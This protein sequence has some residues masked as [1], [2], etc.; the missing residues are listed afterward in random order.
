[1]SVVIV[2]A[3]IGGLTA[4]LALRAQG[5]EVQV[6]EQARELS[7]IGAGLQIASNAV[8]VLDDLGL[9]ERLAEVSVAAR[10]IRFRDLASDELLFETPLGAQAAKH[11]GRPFYQVH[12]ADLLGVL[13]DALPAE[14]LRLGA[15]VT[16]VERDED[17]ATVVLAGGER[18]T[19]DAVI[20]ADGIHSRV[21]E[22]MLGPQEP[23]FSGML[24]WRALLSLEAAEDLGLDHSCDAWLGPGRSVVTYW[25]RRG[26]LFNVIGFV[27]ARE[28][29]RESWTDSGDVYEMRASFAG[30]NALI[31]RL[32]DKID[33]AFI[34]GVYF[35]DPA[36]R[37]STGRVTLL[38]DAAHATQPYLAQGACQSVEDAAVLA[39]LLRRAGPGGVAAALAEYERRRWPRTTKVQTVARA[40]ERFW[41]ETDPERIRAR[42]GRFRGL[43][44]IDALTDTVWGWLYH[45]DPIAS[46]DRPAEESLGLATAH[47][48][49]RMKR[50]ESQR[51][52]DL[53]RAAFTPEDHAGSWQGLRTGY[54]RFL[55]ANASAPADAKVEEVDAG[56]VRALWVGDGGGPTVLHVHGG[57]FM[58]GSA[59]GAVGLADRIA[60]AVGGRVL[61]VDYR[62]AP[63][64]PYP[65]ALDDVL[66]AY[67]WLVE[68]DD[69]SPPILCGESAGGGLALSAALALRDRRLTP[70]AAIYVM[71]PLADL[72]VG[73]L[74]VD[75]RKGQDPVLDRDLLTE[76]SAAYL[77]GHNPRDPLASPIHGNFTGLPPLLVHASACEALLDDARRVIEVAR[78]AGVDAELRLFQDTVHIFPLLSFLPEADE[79]LDDLAAFVRER[80]AAAAHPRA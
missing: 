26:E 43:A 1:M 80:T 46:L 42:N 24:G 56:G 71:S 10:A 66:A 35:H 52:A 65:A 44:R 9:A 23:H 5:I 68:Q 4:A 48:A 18:I 62:L 47:D 78:A 45:Y 12:R 76:M 8:R 22:W 16:D 41:H 3:G 77:Q 2:G 40:A 67:A 11:Y 7:E 74:S 69:A 33:S 70:P 13:A 50:P 14:L 31:A 15:T 19:G 30:S 51:A 21:R 64:H 63:E 6:L 53:W 49:A 38:G 57:G 32:M 27:P 58:F 75:E 61:A 17:S 72:E 25:L 37:W 54:D 36:P 59:R 34:T 79:A 39:R 28:V 20:G 73:G 55:A 29:H 60:S